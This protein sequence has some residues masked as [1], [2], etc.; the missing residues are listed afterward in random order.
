MARRKK[1]T[2][3]LYKVRNP[4]TGLFLVSKSSKWTKRS[5]HPDGATFKTFQ[6][7]EEMIHHYL[8]NV[9]YFGP[10]LEIVEVMLTEV[11]VSP[12]PY[13][14]P[15]SL[16]DFM[17]KSQPGG[18]H[19][20]PLWSSL[21]PSRLSA[22][23]FRSVVIDGFT[24]KYLVWLKGDHDPVTELNLTGSRQFRK[25]HDRERTYLAVDDA[26]LVAIKLAHNDDIAQVWDY[27]KCALIEG[28]EWGY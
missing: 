5:W 24:P 14:V 4:A 10:P 3:L 7:A 1:P 23:A 11:S 21:H 16:K 2:N 18:Y 15:D 28:E 12:R 27:A 17:V 26:G 20:Q 19:F 13:V 22:V 9:D 6:K 8:V 25:V